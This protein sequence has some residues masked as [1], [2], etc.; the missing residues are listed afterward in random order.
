MHTKARHAPNV[1]VVNDTADTLEMLTVM[2]EHHGYKV[3]STLEARHALVLARVEQ[4][5]I[6]VCDVVMPGMSGLDLC[7]RLKQDKLT[8]MIPILLISGLREGSEN[9]LLGLAEGADDYLE[10]PGGLN[11][12]PVKVARLAE[13][14]RVERHYRDLVEQTLD[15]IYTS[16]IEGRITSINEAG[17][18]FFGRPVEEL[19]GVPLH[20]L[21]C[22]KVG[23]AIDVTGGQEPDDMLSL[24]YRGKDANGELRY[25]EAVNTLLCDSKGQSV[26][27][28]GVMR[29]ITERKRAEEA[30]RESEERYRL[31]FEGNP[32]PMWVYD[33]ETLA[34]LAVN[35]AAVRSYGYTR[36]EF[37]AMT[38]KDIRPPSEVPSLL[39]RIAKLDKR[40]STPRTWQHRKKDGSIIEAEI[41][42]DETVFAGRRAR[43]VLSSDI[44][45]RKRAEAALTESEER[46]RSLFDNTSDLIQSVAH[47]GQILYVNRAWRETLGYTQEEIS[48]LSIFDIIHPDHH[49]YYLE[50]F[51]HTMGGHKVDSIET[52]FVAKDNREILVEGN[53]SWRFVD[54]KQVST[55]GIFRNVTE[56]RR[57]DD[58]LRESEERL[59]AQYQGFPV[60]TYSWRKV[61]DDFK[62]IDFNDAAG[63]LTYGRAADLV[64]RRASEV[65]QERPD[66]LADFHRCRNEKR[67]IKRETLYRMKSTNEDKNLSITYVCVPP[68]IVMAHLEDIT[69]RKKAEEIEARMNDLIRKAALEWRTTFDEIRF[70][71]LVAD[72]SGCVK[73][74]NSAAQQL[75]GESYNE[76]I[77]RPVEAL[78]P[79]QPWQKAAELVSLLKTTPAGINCQVKDET[80]GKTWDITVSLAHGR[81]EGDDAEVTLIARDITRRVQLEA[82]L[83][84]SDMLSMMGSLVAGVA[85]EVRNPLFAISS[86][87]DAFEARFGGQKDY[88]RYFSVLKTELERLNDL[89]QDLLELGKPLTQ[90]YYQGS[91]DVLI[92][93][94]IRSCGPLAARAKVEVV[95]IAGEDLPLLS[96]DR[97]RVIQVMLNLLENAIHHSPING[98]IVVETEKIQR[99]DGVWVECRVK[100]SGPGFRQ[101]D[102]P[103][104]FEPF[105]TRRRK[106]SG[107]GLSI[108]LRI[109]EEHKGTVTPANRPEGGAVMTLG[110]PAQ[111]PDE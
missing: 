66:I 34:F 79:G 8:A 22:S 93:Q 51:Q 101:E 18:R 95:K 28:R 47:D 78:G 45:M 94:A 110:F 43:L 83:K 31:L 105:F 108:V 60:P 89:M 75:S 84:R 69:A 53:T 37:L 87:L 86:T 102:L 106:G 80:S 39:D 109:M 57:A 14:H 13:R 103:K 54:G 72:L 15:I 88:Q 20:R 91:L 30:L 61:V 71:L 24:I 33:H 40:L 17:S 63:D 67:I 21:I 104:I 50:V 9:R 111:M 29:N 38:I 92:D 97:R 46:Y 65:Y 76:L 10:M 36:E 41:T 19:I 35:E 55:Q 32:Q 7:R 44:T 26:G 4:P 49:A 107:L 48:H 99:G 59:R 100:D 12:L 73:R 58:S 85:H 70:P 74:L 77:G 25:L 96:M 42:S 98:Q 81:V 5:D 27:V 56:R 1:L 52:V 23:S 16:D 6:I 82:A 2:L 68:D 64:G 11:E 62:L 90:E 3:V